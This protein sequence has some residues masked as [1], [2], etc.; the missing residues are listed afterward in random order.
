MTLIGLVYAGMPIAHAFANKGLNVLGFD[1][2]DI[3]TN[4]AIDGM[5][6]KRNALAFRL[7]LGG[8]HCIGVDTF[9]FTY[10]VEKLGYHVR[11]FLAT[12]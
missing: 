4:E 7:V 6:A 11:L 9:Y 1:W 5:N 3:D 8:G 12:V 10:Q 2:M